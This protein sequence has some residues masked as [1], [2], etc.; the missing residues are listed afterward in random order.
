LGP[1]LCPISCSSTTSGQ[2]PCRRSAR[3]G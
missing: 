2:H 1:L 3:V